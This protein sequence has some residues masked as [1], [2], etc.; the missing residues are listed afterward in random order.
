AGKQA[1]RIALGAGADLAK[2]GIELAA[3]AQEQEI[4]LELRESGRG[5]ERLDGGRLL[6]VGAQ[7]DE[8]LL[9]PRLGR[10]SVTAPLEQRAQPEKVQA[11]TALVLQQK[12]AAR[13]LAHGTFTR[14]RGSKLGVGL[15]KLATRKLSHP[16]TRRRTK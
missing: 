14:S 16:S 3:R 11:Q 8:R 10:R 2:L 6:H 4:A 15:W 12:A 7:P 1:L 5:D 9:R 13:L